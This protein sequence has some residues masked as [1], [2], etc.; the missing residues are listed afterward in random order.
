MISV[1]NDIRMQLVVERRRPDLEMVAPR[2]ACRFG[3]C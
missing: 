2:L 3:G 1:A